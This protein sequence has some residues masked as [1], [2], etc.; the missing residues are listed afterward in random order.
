MH[1]TGAKLAKYLIEDEG[2]LSSTFDANEV[3]V[4]TTMD[5]RTI[6]SA[7]A[8]L[9]GMYNIA[10]SYPEEPVVPFEAYTPP[11]RDDALLR[12]HD[13]CSLHYTYKDVGKAL[14]AGFFAKMD[15]DMETSGYY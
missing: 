3:Y 9:E 13:Q 8:H 6:A 12:P 11:K 2:F 5:Q 15:Y 4:Q 10:L 7:Q 14:A 1:L